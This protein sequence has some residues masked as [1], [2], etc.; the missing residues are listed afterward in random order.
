MNNE[1]I[2]KIQYE[3]EITA[4]MD[5]MRA[6]GAIMCDQ[7]GAWDEPFG[8]MP[9]VEI[10]PCAPTMGESWCRPC[11][12]ETQVP[13]ESPDALTE[14]FHC[15]EWDW[16]SD[17]EILEDGAREA[18]A[19]HY[20]SVNRGDAIWESFLEPTGDRPGAPIVAGYRWGGRGEYDV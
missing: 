7:C 17:G 6:S 18:W 16:E 10:L 1:T 4:R 3:S 14:C 2:A 11:A 8:L 12:L 15:G 20:C 5:A 9:A 19:C 13:G